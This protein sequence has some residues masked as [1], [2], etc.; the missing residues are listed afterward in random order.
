MRRRSRKRRGRFSA[1]IISSTAS[2]RRR[3]SN[4]IELV[5]LPT[6]AGLHSPKICARF[7]GL[8]LVSETPARNNGSNGVDRIVLR[9]PGR[10]KRALCLL[11]LLAQARRG[12][13]RRQ[14]FCPPVHYADSLLVS[15]CT[16]MEGS[17]AQ[18]RFVQLDRFRGQVEPEIRSLLYP[19]AKVN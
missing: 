4:P 7:R 19:V 14:R 13:T 5:L 16:P 1:P 6:G 2:I 9:S 17:G 12:G 18:E 11:L 8:A 10:A 15:L 3:S